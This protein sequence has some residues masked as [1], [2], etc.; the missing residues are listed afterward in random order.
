MIKKEFLILITLIIVCFSCSEDNDTTTPRNLQEYIATISNKDFGNVIACAASAK[1]SSSL[2]YI[3][4]YPEEGATDIRYYEADSLSISDVNDLSSYSRRT[5]EIEDVFG[6]KL[7]RFSRTD[8]TEN[9][10][11]VT[12]MLNGKLHKSNPIR[13]KN[14]SN[15]T[16]YTDQI[17]IEYP[18][19]LTPKFT[20]SDF[21]ETDN[22]VYF[23]VISEKEEG[24]FFSGVYIG[25]DQERVFQYNDFTNSNID[26]NLFSLINTATPPDLELD[27]EYLFT[28]MAVTKDN[29]VNTI[30]EEPFV[31]GNLQEYFDDVSLNE[32][33]KITSFAASKNGND[34]ICLVYVYPQTNAF[35]I[36]YYETENTSVDEEDFTKYRRKML[37]EELVFGL[38]FRQFSRVEDHE[39][40]YIVTYQIDDIIYR[41]DPIQL[42]NKSQPTV[43]KA[44]TDLEVTFPETLVPLFT[45]SDF[46]ITTNDRYFHLITTNSSSF[47]S[48]VYTQQNSF[49]YNDFSNTTSNINTITPPDLILENTY[50]T[51][52][53][54]ISNENWV[55]LVIEKSFD[56]E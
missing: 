49:K 39:S 4:Y 35:N 54:G 53:L 24:A 51:K 43:W 41:S 5:L 13:L 30:I 22:D 42:K 36:R 16:T 15:K 8:E 7:K 11:L 37:D 21:N 1:E 14:I 2:T 50:K 45:W 52:V 55:N 27:I 40:W 47:I 44:A 25:A 34:N 29:W 28:S 38:Q 18:T 20:W 31:L 56:I 46:G 9:W 17:T 6:G 23:Q 48:G 32:T 33:D 26:Q 3:F 12:Y 10:C 19:T